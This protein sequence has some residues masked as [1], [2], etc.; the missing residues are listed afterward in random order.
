M[1]EIKFPKKREALLRYWHGE[2]WTEED[3]K[4]FERERNDRHTNTW[5]NKHRDRYNACMKRAQDKWR[6]EH[7]YYYGWKQWNK[8]HPDDQMTEE[9]YT[10][11]RQNKERQKEVKEQKNV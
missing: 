6:V 10:A 7:P 3:Q 8:L 1:K 4:Q 5:R 11:Y 9:Q 2:N